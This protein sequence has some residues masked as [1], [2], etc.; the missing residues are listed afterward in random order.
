MEPE[1][2]GVFENDALAGSG[3]NVV[4]GVVKSLIMCFSQILHVLA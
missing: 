1:L 4:E 3:G 2:I